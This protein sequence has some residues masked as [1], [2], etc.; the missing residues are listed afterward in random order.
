MHL[1]LWW[2]MRWCGEHLAKATFAQY[3]WLPCCLTNLNVFFPHR[4]SGRPI[5]TRGRQSHFPVYDICVHASTVCHGPGLVMLGLYW[6]TRRDPQAWDGV[7][8]NQ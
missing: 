8:D 1:C 4:M 2:L 5:N 6:L 3:D 7:G